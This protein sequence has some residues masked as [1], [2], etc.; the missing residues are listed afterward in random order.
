MSRYV[1]QTE[2]SANMFLMRRRRSACGSGVAASVTRLLVVVGFRVEERW[3]FFS[4]VVSVASSST[5]GGGSI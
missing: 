5:V 2:L 3:S 4:V 1:N